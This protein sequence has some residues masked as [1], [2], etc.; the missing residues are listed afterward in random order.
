MSAVPIF[1]HVSPHL[2]VLLS[3][4]LSASQGSIILLLLDRIST[5]F[6]LSLY[7]FNVKLLLSPALAVT[8]DKV[9]LCTSTFDDSTLEDVLFCVCVSFLGLE[10]SPVLST[11]LT[12][13]SLGLLCDSS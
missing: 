9:S 1:L 5:H 3:P 4:E 10:T 8:L 7:T 13:F 11:I 2:V 6:A 12:S